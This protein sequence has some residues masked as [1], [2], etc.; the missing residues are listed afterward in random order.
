MARPTE[1]NRKI[2]T[3]IFN[4]RIFLEINCKS[5]PGLFLNIFEIAVWRHALEG[6]HIALDEVVCVVVG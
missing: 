3:N 4:P 5:I 2:E 1:S 6:G